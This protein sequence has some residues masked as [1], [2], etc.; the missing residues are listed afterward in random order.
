MKRILHKQSYQLLLI[1]QN[2]NKFNYKIIFYGK[3]LN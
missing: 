3:I 1:E 2:Q